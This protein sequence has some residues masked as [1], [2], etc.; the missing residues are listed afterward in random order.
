MTINSRTNTANSGSGFGS[1]AGSGSD[2]GSDS[3]EGA[4]R[5]E[6]GQ[7]RVARLVSDIVALMTPVL[8]FAVPVVLVRADAVGEGFLFLNLFS[9]FVS[10]LVAA[11]APMG[12]HARLH[13]GDLLSARTLTG[14]RTVDLSRLTKVGR[15]E[16][17]GQ[18]RTDDRLILTD[19]HGVRLILNNLAG[20][21]DTV[22][23]LVRRALLA[24]P[25][26]AGVVV[27][28]RAAERLD[29]QAEVTRPHGRLKAGR[30][31]REGFI[32]FVPLLSLFVVA[33]VTFGLC[34]LAWLLAAAN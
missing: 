4:V 15:L 26:G 25:Q 10:C 34:V 29:L 33:P 24:R 32:G 30:K 3:T 6:S 28:D 12:W 7:G 2:S 22:D 14:R 11:Y 13:E 1:D 21:K 8:T 23:G 20:G 16:V 17:P 9:P 18:T 31:V 19:A 5:V 27:S